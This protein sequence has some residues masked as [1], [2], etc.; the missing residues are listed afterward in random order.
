MLAADGLEFD[1]SLTGAGPETGKADFSVE[2]EHGGTEVS[3]EI[4]VR[5]ATPGSVHEVTV[6]GINVGVLQ[7]NA[8]G[9]GK[10]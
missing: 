10:L 8:R 6:D 3:L 7:V 5:N 4:E 9:R 2:D 1:S